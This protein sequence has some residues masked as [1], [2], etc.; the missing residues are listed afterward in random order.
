MHIPLTLYRRILIIAFKKIPSTYDGI[1]SVESVITYSSNSFQ[2]PNL[3]MEKNKDAKL[4]KIV[5]GR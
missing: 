2:H 4:N 5:V 3:Y 1:N